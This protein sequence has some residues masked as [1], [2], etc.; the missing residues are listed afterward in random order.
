METPWVILVL[1]EE[2]LMLNTPIQLCVWNVWSL[3]ASF[4]NSKSNLKLFP[5]YF[6]LP[7]KDGST[8][9]IWRK[10]TTADLA[11]IHASKSSQGPQQ[12][13]DSWAN[14]RQTAHWRSNRSGISLVTV[15]PPTPAAYSVLRFIRTCLCK[16]ANFI[17][18]PLSRRAERYN[19]DYGDWDSDWRFQGQTAVPALHTC[20]IWQGC[21]NS[22]W[23]RRGQ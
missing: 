6:F 18:R 2:T 8:R 21:W 9:P 13:P 4:Q 1:S 14:A 11:A 19:T 5:L 12:S 16:S 23:G 17:F 20:Q 7:F 15:R 10:Q 22:D 3:N